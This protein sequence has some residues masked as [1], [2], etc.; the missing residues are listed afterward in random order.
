MP[1]DS[2]GFGNCRMFAA[3]PRGLEGPL[4]R[5]KGEIWSY[6]RLPA[7]A[8]RGPRPAGGPGGD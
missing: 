8:G 5:V 1:W 7:E 6:A 2:R 4:P 3:P